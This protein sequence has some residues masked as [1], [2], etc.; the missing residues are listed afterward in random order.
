VQRIFVNPAIKKALCR[1]AGGDRAW[2][3]KVR[4]WWVTTTTSTSAYAARATA[5]NASRS[6]QRAEVMA[7]ARNSTHG[8]PRLCS[9]PGRCQSRTSRGRA[10][11]C[12]ASRR[13]A[14][15]CL[16]RLMRIR[17]ALHSTA[18]QRADRDLQ[19]CA[20]IPPQGSRTNS[21]P[22]LAVAKPVNTSL[23]VS[24]FFSFFMLASQRCTFG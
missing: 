23:M 20:G 9:T 22:L 13:P 18:A 17:W 10:S 21:L 15:R 16:R 7:A 3:Q 14:P 19:S 24:Q 12:L 2:L 5:P 6:R 1:E 8:L 11:P 4:P